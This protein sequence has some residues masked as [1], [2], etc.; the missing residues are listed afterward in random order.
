MKQYIDLITTILQ[1][2]R[3]K[4][5]RTGTGTIS[6]FG[7]QSVY[8]MDAGFPLL[9][10]KKTYPRGV[11][12]ELLWFL[13]GDTNI[14]YLNE[15]NVHIWDEWSQNAGD[16]PDDKRI[17][18]WIKRKKEVSYVSYN[19]DFSTKGINAK[20]ETIDDKLRNA[21]AKMMKRCYLTTS[22]NYKFYGEKGVFVSKEWHNPLTFINDVKTLQ[23]WNLKKGDWNTFELDKDYYGTNCYSKENCVW[24]HTAENNLY[25]GQPIEIILEGKTKIYHSYKEAEN[26]LN[27]PTTT[28]QRWC[29]N[30]V[31]KILKGNNK[32]FEGIQ[33]K[34][35]SKDGYLFRKTF[36]NG[37]LGPIY[38]KQWVDLGGYDKKVL[39][40]KIPE[41]GKFKV[42]QYVN[43]HVK[44]INQIQNVIDT[45]KNNPDSRRIIVD[46]WNV[47]ELDKMAL[48]PCHT[49]FQ[50]ITE[51][52]TTEERL[53]IYANEYTDGV[54]GND[55]FMETKLETRNIPKF[56]LSLQ[57]YQRSA[58]T[59]L[60]VPFNVAS[61]ALLLHM[62]AQVV[63]MKPYKFVHTMGDAHLYLN[64]KDQINEFLYRVEEGK[65]VHNKSGKLADGLDYWNILTSKI[66]GEEK[67]EYS[68]LKHYMG[69]K[70]PAIRLNPKIKNIFDFKIEDIELV[71]YNPMSAIKAPV[72]V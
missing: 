70:L 66:L 27:I 10:L 54:K 60:G 45:L 33:I 17:D 2:G 57:L 36:T 68:P 24:L 61:Y 7:H 41:G 20:K 39:T 46:A 62:V 32:Q 44:G 51:P 28:L 65:E 31:P 25:I 59:F 5:D 69:P 38:G 53:E 26:D 34:S 64:H 12:E 42:D 47:Q 9:T 3:V 15:R 16:F 4:T 67:L 50:F 58:D 43:H 35:I 30:G 19:G 1:E 37:E 13:K 49:L 14:K 18:A 29:V 72:A 63:N 52:L 48:T 40:R 6:I 21:W 56:R 55:S 8:Y 11:F 71:D 22:H 23:N